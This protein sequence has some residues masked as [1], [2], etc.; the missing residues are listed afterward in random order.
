MYGFTAREFAM[1][2][3]D[4]DLRNRNRFLQ[5]SVDELS[6][7]IETLEATVD[8]ITPDDVN[9]VTIQPSGM[10]EVSAMVDGYR[11][12]RMYGGHTEAGA[13]SDFI[14]RVNNSRSYNYA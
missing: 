14:R 3:V 9:V 6:A 13:V 11:M 7:R 12:S 8:K 5:A 10:L 2:R 4:K 1:M